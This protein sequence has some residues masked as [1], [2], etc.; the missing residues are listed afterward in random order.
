MRKREGMSAAAGFLLFV[1]QPAL[2]ADSAAVLRPVTPWDLDYGITQCSA[3]RDYGNADDPVTFAIVPAPEG[4]TYSLLIGYKKVAP[5]FAEEFEGSVDFGF[6]PTPAWLLRYGSK[7]R[8]L[9]IYQ[10]RIGA[11]EMEQARSAHSVT[12]HMKGAPDASFSLE[13]MPALLDGLRQCTLDLEDYWNAD[14]EKNGRIAVQSKGDVRGIFSADDYPREATSLHQQ[15]TAQY[16]LMIDEKGKVAGCHVVMPSGVPILDA[17]GCVVIQERARFTP[18]LG[19][20][21]KPVRSMLVTP[22]VQ[23]R[24]ES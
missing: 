6:G 22:K 16:L 17:M 2:A 19:T 9:T 4:D 15:G 24:L 13:H 18:A 20:D 8:K 10:F 14:G 5:E 12:V 7:N 23:W 21:G 11:A 3:T 1:G